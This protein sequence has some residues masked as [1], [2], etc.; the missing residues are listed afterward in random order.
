MDY[1]KIISDTTDAPPPEEPD[2]DLFNLVSSLAPIILTHPEEKFH[3]ADLDEYFNN[4]DIYISNDDIQGRKLN[5]DI[6]LPKF[7]NK[8]PVYYRIREQPNTDFIYITYWLFYYFNGPKRVFGLVPTGAHNADIETISI[9][10][11]KTNVDASIGDN[12]NSRPSEV[13]KYQLIEYNLSSHGDFVS[14]SIDNT[15]GHNKFLPIGIIGSSKNY[16]DLHDS[17]K[18]IVYSAIN[19]HALYNQE[20]VYLRKFGFGND[21]C[22]YNHKFAVTTNPKLLK[23]DSVIYRW[24]GRFG[25]NGVNGFSQRQNPWNNKH[26][27]RP[28][29]ISLPLSFLAYLS[30]L[31]L[32]ILT[33][34]FFKN[35]ITKSFTVFILQFYVFKSIFTLI[36]PKITKQP[37]DKDPFKNWI[38]PFKFL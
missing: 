14:H 30:Y 17:G 31:V 7:K 15:L 13:T 23:K 21:T 27:A 12:T 28:T 37:V 1:L 10:L 25:D 5:P 16:I 29:H 26:M 18:P 8:V 11:L 32:P 20:G 19:S 33:Y 3:L 38:L 35:N 4:S 6:L 2:Q 34:Y 22:K 36:L 9:K 24:K